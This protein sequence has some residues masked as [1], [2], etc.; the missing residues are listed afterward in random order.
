MDRRLSAIMFADVVGFS[1]M[2]SSDEAGTL[3][4]LKRF[5]RET[6]EPAVV[7]G[8]GRIVKL[9]GDGALAEFRSITEALLAA[10][11]IQEGTPQAADQP[12][13]SEPI[14]LRI[15]IH[16]GDVIVDGRDIYGDGVNVAARLE[17][18]AP[19]GGIVVSATALEHVTTRLGLEVED[20][21]PQ[22]LK[23]IRRPIRACRVSLASGKPADTGTLDRDA[24]RSTR[25][26][27]IAVLPFANLSGDASQNYFVDGL[28]EDLIDALSC[29]RSFAVIA[30]NSSFAFRGRDLDMRALGA[31]LQARYVLAGSLR[32]SGDRIR[33]AARLTDAEENR[34]VWSGQFDRD[35]DDLFAIQDDISRRIAATVA[36]ELEHAENLKSRRERRDLTAWDCYVRGLHAFNLETCEGYADARGEFE[37]AVE[38][39]PEFVDAWAR[40][41]W[42]HLRAMSEGCTDDREAAIEKSLHL[43][44]HALE[45]DDASAVAHLCLGTAYVWSGMLEEGLAEAERAL[46]LN[47][48]YAHAA[49]AVGNRMDLVG[50]SL[51]GIEHMQMGLQLNPRDP[52]HR[53]TYMIYLSRA[54]LSIGRLE[55]ALDWVREAVALRPDHPDVHFRHAICLAHLDR[56]DEAREALRKCEA[57]RSGFL[58][59]RRD[60][61]PYRDEGRNNQIFLGLRTHGLLAAADRID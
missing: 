5:R 58:R 30:R 57:C 37:K 15:G 43:V 36:P 60:W 10:T 59:T 9:M 18:L 52:Q 35:L 22:E 40:L 53:W 42:T 3:A 61:R 1:R 55:A 44:R 48:N 2:M 49:M 20:L 8:G 26:P 12:D 46:E 41:A 51:E 29:W 54:H 21:G 11:A 38:R 32:R 4:R 16:V 19:P 23:N 17:G 13:A 28:S 25:R 24:P 56:A 7:A 34:Q 27:F 47:P 39:D 50:R 31:A 45:I 6:F 14:Q 33:V